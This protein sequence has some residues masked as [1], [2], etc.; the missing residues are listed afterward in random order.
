MSD[1]ART[2]PDVPK[3]RG[4]RKPAKKPSPQNRAPGPSAGSSG[5]GRYDAGQIA[6]PAEKIGGLLLGENIPVDLMVELL[7]AMLWLEH[8]TGLPTNL[9]VSSCATLHFA[10]AQLGID[11]HPRAVDLVVGNRRTDQHTMY[12]QPDPYWSGSTFHGHCVLW[13]PGS[14]RL[15]D[16]TVEQY[17][18]IRRHEL[19]PI[20]GRI[21]ASM[22]TPAQQA[23][24]ARGELPPGTA[25]GV[26][27]Q[28]LILLYTTVDPEFDDI[29]MSAPVIVDNLAEIQRAGRN[30]A[31]IALNLLCQ[32]DVLPRARRAP[33]PRVRALLDLLAGA[34][35]DYDDDD[36]LRFILRS[37]PTQTPQRLDELSPP[38]SRSSRSR[39]RTAI[40]PPQI[41][42]GHQEVPGT[43][44]ALPRRGL[45]ARLL[46]RGG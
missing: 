5:R 4:R 38:P 32:P 44:T 17:P 18:E 22:A 27:R 6:S 3:S 29:V 33:H 30:L 10:Y 37:D 23:E 20:C 21:V 40:S 7:P 13:L 8:A 11:A 28:D 14:K 45:L 12:G 24:L 2:V 15:I 16:P 42:A 31:A 25:V 19:G 39:S 41:P 34:E 36:E 9:C 26:E 1:A 46:R 43:S 35:A